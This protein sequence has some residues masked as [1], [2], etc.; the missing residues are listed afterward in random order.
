MKSEM[1]K[2]M[3]DLVK[4]SQSFKARPRSR[5]VLYL[6]HSLTQSNARSSSVPCACYGKQL[7]KPIP[8]DLVPILAKDEEKQ[9]QDENGKPRISGSGS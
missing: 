3:A 2:R 5:A 7:N 1:D 4:F 8:D 6:C 9:K